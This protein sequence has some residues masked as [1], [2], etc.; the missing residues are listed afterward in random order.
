MKD[1]TDMPILLRRE[2]EARIAGPLIQAYIE[3]IGRE[4]ALKVASAVMKKR[5]RES[6]AELASQCEGISLR[7]L[8]TGTSKWSEGGAN[9]SELIAMTET[10]FD[11][12]I[13]RCKYAEMYQALGLSDLGFVLSC[14]RDAEMFSGFNPDIEFSR[15]TTIME[16]DKHCDF[17]L[18]LG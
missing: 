3:E 12:N 11:F 10:N 9:E 6:G 15:T 16:G 4:K 14:D 5:A 13:V 1:Q 17:R 2:I 8:A 7:D 18:S